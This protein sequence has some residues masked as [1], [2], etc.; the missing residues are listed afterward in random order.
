MATFSRPGA[1]SQAIWRDHAKLKR[2][3]S[4]FGEAEVAGM[5]GEE[6]HR[7]GS[8]TKTRFHEPNGV[9]LKLTV[10]VSSAF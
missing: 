3:R 5:C 7:G 6:D 9:S 2:E 10:K 1:G 4:Q 8:Y